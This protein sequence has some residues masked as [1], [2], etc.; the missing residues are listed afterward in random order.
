MKL[1]SI[2]VPCFNQAQFLHECLQSVLT[3]TY[4]NWECIIINDGSIDNT[5]ETIE[6]LRLQND[7][8]EEKYNRL[9]EENNSL[10]DKQTT[11]EQN[12]TT[13]LEKLD[14]IEAKDTTYAQ[15]EEVAPA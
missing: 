9:L 3:Q 5:V 11:W 15:H 4:Q 1:V 12:L 7:E 6:L 14:A 13:M 8:L 2:I 10:K